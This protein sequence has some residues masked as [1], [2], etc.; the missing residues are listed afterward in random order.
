MYLQDLSTFRRIVDLQYGINFTTM[1]TAVAPRVTTVP[2]DGISG[3]IA[4]ALEKHQRQHIAGN[5]SMALMIDLGK[6][7]AM[8]LLLTCRINFNMRR[9][10]DE[11]SY[12][13]STK[14]DLRRQYN[15]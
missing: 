10:T 3:F 13:H 12:M 5:L 7:L 14:L 15:D 1:A 2:G 11:K 4:D 6:G 8:R 9:A